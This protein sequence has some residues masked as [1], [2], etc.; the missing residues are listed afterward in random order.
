MFK[1]LIKLNIEY[2]GLDS[3]C[4]STREVEIETE[5]EIKIY[6]NEVKIIIFEA[7]KS[8]GMI[9]EWV[10]VDQLWLSYKTGLQDAK[11]NFTSEHSYWQNGVIAFLEIQQ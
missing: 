11:I 4:G 10:K 6:D 9:A 7:M 5:K 3:L 8:V 1:Y 2:N